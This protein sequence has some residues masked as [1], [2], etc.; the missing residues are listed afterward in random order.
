[1][2]TGIAHLLALAWLLIF[3]HPLSQEQPLAEL[4][5]FTQQV[6]LRISNNCLQMGFSNRTQAVFDLTQC[7]FMW[8]NLTKLDF[9]P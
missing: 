3:T 7:I 9:V 8:Q 1:M 5:I 4:A 2:P 6:I